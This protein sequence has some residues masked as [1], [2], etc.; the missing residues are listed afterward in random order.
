[1][2]S[3]RSKTPE[4]KTIPVIHEEILPII[5]L[6]IQPVFTKEIQPIIEE[7]IQPVIFME[8]QQSN[9]E[10]II[11]QIEQSHKQKANSNQNDKIQEKQEKEELKVLPYV[12]RIE[13]H[14]TQTVIENHT[15][16]K[17]VCSCKIKYVP[18]IQYKNGELLLYKK[19]SNNNNFGY[20]I[21]TTTTTTTASLN[22]IIAINFVS[23]NH[24]INYPMACRK[25]DIFAKIE[26]KLYNE[27]P[28]LKTKK[29]YFIVSGNI[30]NKSY[31]FE[32]NK[33]KSG[34]TIL[35]NEME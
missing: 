5:H 28:E 17:V 16:K 3:F 10:E 35:I 30:V 33:I 7:R 13:Q 18:Y 32:Q 19:N 9:I 8:D 4:P 6:N 29:L 11:Q 21:I 20:P 2:Y 23:L 25:T 26:N 14:T 12:K 1:M 22:E 24:N 27:F 34:D 15:E 31:T